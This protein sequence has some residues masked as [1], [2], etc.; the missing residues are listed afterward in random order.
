MEPGP[1]ESE[2]NI[3]ITEIA[4]TNVSMHTRGIDHRHPI[5]NLL[6]SSWV[7]L[8]FA[9]V[10]GSTGLYGY[11]DPFWA[12]ICLYAAGAVVALRVSTFRAVLAMRWWKICLLL[13]PL[14]AACV[15]APY[16]LDKRIQEH[17]EAKLLPLRFQPAD[18]LT[19]TRRNFIRHTFIQCREYIGE[20]GLSTHT[21]VPQI[22]V[23]NGKPGTFGGGGYSV[24]DPPGAQSTQERLSIALA[25]IDNKTEV[26]ASYLWYELF[27]TIQATSDDPLK[28]TLR[29]VEALSVYTYLISD[30]SARHVP[31]YWDRWSDS[32]WTI[33]AV[34]SRD[35]A[36][37][38][39]V[40]MVQDI[41]NDKNAPTPM[42]AKESVDSYKDKIMR[43][44][45]MEALSVTDDIKET[46]RKT[47]EAIIASYGGK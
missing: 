2:Q 7:A 3:A 20:I 44:Y 13:I 36:N 17:Q 6:E 4:I 31:G 27:K 1:P 11:S 10:L 18:E 46:H 40:S 38:L 34:I 9:F 32:F 12:R 5:A 23:S 42:G 35:F 39:V 30:F 16:Y 19:I 25:G 33:R 28:M 47:V 15:F 21:P 45:V 26:C 14:W 29:N 43:G 41:A 37:S 22:L 8:M 24:V